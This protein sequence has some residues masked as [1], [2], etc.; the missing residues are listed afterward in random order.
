MTQLLLGEGADDASGDG[1]GDGDS[2]VRCESDEGGYGVNNTS[3]M[4]RKFRFRLPDLLATPN[5]HLL[6][7]GYEFYFKDKKERELFQ[8]MVE[9]AGGKVMSPLSGPC[10]HLD[11]YG[12]GDGDGD[13]ACPHY[14][15]LNHSVSRGVLGHPR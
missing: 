12:D 11:V 1:D 9:S 2:D 10:P 13:G 7:S 6:F 8:K 15:M 4:E 14:L 3:E 5:R